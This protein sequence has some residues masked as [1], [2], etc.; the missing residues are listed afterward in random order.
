VAVQVHVQRSRPAK[1]EGETKE[2]R[3]KRWSENRICEINKSDLQAAV[4]V[5]GGGQQDLHPWHADHDPGGSHAATAEG[6]N[7]LKYDFQKIQ[8]RFSKLTN[9]IC[10]AYLL[11][12]KIE[13]ASWRLR[14]GDLGIPH[15]PE[16]RLRHK[17]Y[18]H[19]YQIPNTSFQNS[20]M[21]SLTQRNLHIKSPRSPSPE[22]QYDSQGKRQNTRDVRKVRT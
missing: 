11:Q 4:T 21:Q 19:K 15:N 3:A 18:F 13:E 14:S 6:A 5:D 8:I 2:E 22:P 16:D 20:Q 17:Y 12:L 9:T 1:R 10:Q 7:T